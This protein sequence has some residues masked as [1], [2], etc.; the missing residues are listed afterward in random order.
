MPVLM[1]SLKTWPHVGFSRKRSIVPSS[2]VMTMP[3]SSGLSTC[4]EADGGH[5]LA[6]VVEGDDLGEVDVGDD[7]AGDDEEALVEVLLGVAHRAGGAERRRLVGV[8]DLHAVVGAVTELVL[9]GVGQERHRHDDLV[10]AVAAQQVD[11]VLH[12]RPVGD[13]QHRLRGV[14]G[15]RAQAGALAAG[16]DDG[17]H[18]TLAR[19]PSASD[20]AHQSGR[21]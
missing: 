10:E 7:V 18:A 19:R 21:R 15:E 8:D 5:R 16:H 2:R 17:L 4:D 9:D 20:S 13:R 3:N 12:H 1:V 6:L 14:R 11:D